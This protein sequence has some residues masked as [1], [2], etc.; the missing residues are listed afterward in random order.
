MSKKSTQ[1]DVVRTSAK[2]LV[3][4]AKADLDRLRDA[5][6]GN[7]DT[8]DISESASFKPLRRDPHGVLPRRRSMIREAIEQRRKQLHLTPYR[9]WKMALPFHS[10]LSQAAVHEFLKGQ[11]QLELPSAEALLAAVKLCVVSFEN[12]NQAGFGSVAKKRA[13]IKRPAK[14]Q[15]K[16]RVH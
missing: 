4:R 16:K 10:S 11:R 15:P 14:S 3:R 1:D 13:G 8:S 2:T 12:E 6:K 9:L 7:V 5:M